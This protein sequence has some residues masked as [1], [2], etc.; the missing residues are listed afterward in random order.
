MQEFGISPPTSILVVSLFFVALAGGALFLRQVSL[1]RRLVTMGTA[2]L[3]AA[4]I[5][6]SSYRPVTITVG[7]DGIEVQGRGGVELGWPEIE[8]A[9]FETNLESSRFRPTVRTRGIAVGGYRIGQFLMSN[10]NPAQVYMQQADAAIVLRSATLTYLLAPI[11]VVA[12]A[13]AIDANRVYEDSA[14]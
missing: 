7:S 10:G 3:A 2:V 5:L 1:R 13:E 6:L 8:S 4:A 11:E 12:L 9:L 14:E